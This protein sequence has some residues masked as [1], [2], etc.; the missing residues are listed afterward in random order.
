MR[1]INTPTYE[2]EDGTPFKTQDECLAYEAELKRLEELTSYWAVH[3]NPDLTEGRGYQ[4]LTLLRVRVD[5][6][7]DPEIWVRDWCHRTLGRP[8][9]FVMGVAPMPNWRISRETAEKYNDKTRAYS[10]LSHKPPTRLLL[11]PGPQTDGL[12]ETPQ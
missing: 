2:A 3:H 7:Q 4:T 5:R 8:L 9:A 1:I 11:Q 12:C 6:Y 10:T